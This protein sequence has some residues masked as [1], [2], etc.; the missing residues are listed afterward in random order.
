MKFNPMYL[1]LVLLAIILVALILSQPT[2]A[3]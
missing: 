2:G 1:I 3:I